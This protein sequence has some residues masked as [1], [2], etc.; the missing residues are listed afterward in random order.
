M[1]IWSAIKE[2][3][4]VVEVGTGSTEQDEKKVVYLLDFLALHMHS[5]DPQGGYDGEE[6]PENDYPS[7]RKMAEERFPNWGYYNTPRDVSEKMAETELVVGDAI[8]DITDIVNDLKMVML[9]Y[10]NESETNAL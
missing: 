4:S 6:V 9:S 7:I 1:D 8:V 10:Q 3:I 5:V 2:L